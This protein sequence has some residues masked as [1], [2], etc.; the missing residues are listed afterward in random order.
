MSTHKMPL[1]VNAAALYVHA[2]DAYVN[3]CA[4]N[5]VPCQEERNGDDGSWLNLGTSEAKCL[6]ST[7]ES[8]LPA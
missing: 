7:C 8:C 2:M 5:M 4:S 1:T 3:F 6:T